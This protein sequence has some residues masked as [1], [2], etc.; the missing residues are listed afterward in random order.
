MARHVKD[1]ALLL[2]QLG[3]LLWCVF[4]LWP[5]NFHTP[6]VQLKQ[7]IF[8]QKKKKGISTVVQLDRQYLWSTGMQ[9]RSP[10]W[11]SVLKIWPCQSCCVGY[12]CGLDLIPRL[13]TPYIAG[14]PKNKNKNLLNLK[15][16][17]EKK[18]ENPGLLQ[19]SVP[20]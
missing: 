5:G 4:D 8:N 16:K 12:N 10:A 20:P 11:H 15:K 3:S 14:W 19:P 13:G 18:K 7:K 2:R 9:V 6:Q 1:L 17:K